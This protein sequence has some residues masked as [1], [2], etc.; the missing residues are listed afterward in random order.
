MANATVG[1][2][3]L[4]FLDTRVR[5][6]VPHA[7]AGDGLSLLESWAPPGDSPPL[8]VHHR[9]DELFYVLKGE[10]LFRVGDGELQRGAG[11]ALLIPK[12]VPHSYR[13]MSAD[14]GRWLV[15]TTD[16]GFE[17]LVR[18]LGR[19]PDGPGL[20]DRGGPPSPAQAKALAAACAEQHI[21]LVGPPLH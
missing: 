21:E 8:H 16:G 14:G 1:T 13:V 10:F 7:G 3:V 5:I 9:E 2:E 12:G 18:A 17:R 11:E 4:W 15:T 6:H 19:R 20:P